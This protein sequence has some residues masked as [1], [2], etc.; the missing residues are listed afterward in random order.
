[1]KST[2]SDFVPYAIFTMGLFMVIAAEWL[3]E[4]FWNE[5]DWNHLIANVGLYVT[6]VVALQWYYDRRATYKTIVTVVETAL[7]NSNVISSGI[8]NCKQDT[9]K[10]DYSG[11]LSHPEEVII[12][13]LHSSRFVD[14]NLE[15]L[16]ERAKSGKKT[17]ILLSDPDGAAIKYLLSLTTIKDHV[18]PNIQK[19][20]SKVEEH[21][22]SGDGIKERIRVKHHDTVLRYSFVQ[23]RD[24]I[25]VKMYQNSRGIAI[26]PGIYIRSGSAMYRFFYDDIQKLKEGAKDG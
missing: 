17:T 26:T 3:P 1:M 22:N 5:I 21:I 4:M 7:S 20:S 15:L 6:V 9:K 18:I 12:G 24:G 2:V 11:Q 14:D 8:E 19:V 23:S 10:I 16:R 25:W 13:F